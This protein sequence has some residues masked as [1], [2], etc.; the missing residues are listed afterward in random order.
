MTKITIPAILLVFGFLLAGCNK[1]QYPSKQVQ[2]E[3]LT[4]RDVLHLVK[5]RYHGHHRLEVKAKGNIHMN[6]NVMGMTR[7]RTMHTTL[8]LALGRAG[9]LRFKG[10]NPAGWSLIVSNGDKVWQY[11]SM[12][13]EYTENK[14]TPLQTGVNHLEKI[15]K[16]VKTKNTT[17]GD[18][19]RAFNPFT[20]SIKSVTG[21]GQ[22]TL[23]MPDSS[24]RKVLKI[25]VDYVQGKMNLNKNYGS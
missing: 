7:N 10:T 6:I 5:Q 17:A 22:D 15:F 13:G 11:I 19:A 9:K 1:S 12:M 24:K 8:Y 23:I 20:D 16:H 14:Y 2:P 4:P 25:K 18:L 21:L 3:N